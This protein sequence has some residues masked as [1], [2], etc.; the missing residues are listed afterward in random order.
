MRFPTFGRRVQYI[1]VRF[2]SRRYIRNVIS[3]LDSSEESNTCMYFPSCF[4]CLVPVGVK[5]LRIVFGRGQLQFE[6][7]HAIEAKL[8]KVILFREMK[9]LQSLS[10]S[11]TSS[12]TWSKTNWLSW[13]AASWRSLRAFT[14]TLGLS[15]RTS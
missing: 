3:L 8:L 5:G 13:I 2:H 11:M 15:I 6:F 12:G 10:E 4:S 1:N 9:I 14:K 7:L